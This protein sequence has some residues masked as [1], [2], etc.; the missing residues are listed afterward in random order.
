MLIQADQSFLLIVDMQER[1]VPAVLEPERT[2]AQVLRLVSGAA[3][4]GVP[5]LATEH[6]P[7]RIGRTI[8]RLRALISE[9]AIVEKTCFSAQAEPAGG[10][11]FA[12][13]KRKQPVIVGTE[14]HVCVMQ[15]AIDLRAAGYRPFIVVEG[16]SSRHALDRDL[17][18]ARMRDQGIGIV[19]VE[20]VLFEWLA[21]GDHKA[22]R[23]IL[24]LIKNAGEEPG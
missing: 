7:E 22:F 12:A 13:L 5:V 17:A 2:I 6:C 19:S 9:Q 14:T 8:P 16:V 3:K 24:P 18:I 1:L 23:E 11:C 4:L 10:A 15:T 21:R 20:M